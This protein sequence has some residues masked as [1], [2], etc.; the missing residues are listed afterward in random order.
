LQRLQRDS[1]SLVGQILV[2]TRDAARATRR[3]QQFVEAL[4]RATVGDAVGACR[5]MVTHLDEFPRDVVMIRAHV[6]LQNA[7]GAVHRKEAIAAQ[8][9]HL[10]PQLGDDPWFLGIHSF[11]LSEI[12]DLP[13]ALQLVERGLAHRP[14]HSVLAHAMAHIYFERGD[15]MGGRDFISGWLKAHG[16]DVLNVGHMAWHLA[17]THVALSDPASA[18]ALYKRQKS[19]EHW[20]TFTLEDAI[21]LLWRLHLRD[22]DVRSEWS[23]LLQRERT[24]VPAFQRAH[25]AFALAAVHDNEGLEQLSSDVQ[26][27]VDARPDTPLRFL[28]PLFAALQLVACDRWAQA[29]PVL[30]EAADGFRRLGGSNEQHALIDETIAFARQR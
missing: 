19:L 2:A 20:K 17:L 21:S 1:R 13:T 9:G 24:D 25:V 6:L 23:N 8:L 3:E 30:E 26:H 14:D 12:G 22:V 10:A 11:A 16:D 15:D 29:R 28:P 5:L 18:L 7:G 4:R 27:D